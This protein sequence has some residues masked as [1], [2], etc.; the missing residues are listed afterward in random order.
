[1]KEAGESPRKSFA[2][3][4]NDEVSQRAGCKGAVYTRPRLT[5]CFENGMWPRASSAGTGVPG[6]VSGMGGHWDLGTLVEL[7]CLMAPATPSQKRY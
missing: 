3:S 5:M 7:L 4:E 6:D 1:M 2:S